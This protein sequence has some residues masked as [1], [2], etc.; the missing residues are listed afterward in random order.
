MGRLE[1]IDRRQLGTGYRDIPAPTQK[2]VD[3]GNQARPATGTSVQWEGLC[4]PAGSIAG[5]S[6]WRTAFLEYP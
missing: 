5:I 2:A 4:R 3:S 1:L 6:E